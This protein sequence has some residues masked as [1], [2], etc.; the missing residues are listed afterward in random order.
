MHAILSGD[1]T[2]RGTRR[3]QMCISVTGRGVEL[4]R[5][6]TGRRADAMV[7]AATRIAR[8]PVTGA[9]LPF[10]TLPARLTVHRK[11]TITMY[12]PH[13][14][15]AALS[16]AA[17]P[18]WLRQRGAPAAAILERLR[19]AAGVTPRWYCSAEALQR[20]A[21]AGPHQLERVVRPRPICSGWQ[22]AR[23]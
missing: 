2:S 20:R 13:P 12:S 3:F 14:A 22:L 21:E 8:A 6:G 7:L 4:R 1:T 19:S 17:G 23:T 18:A 10:V 5:L 9:I 15:N 16:C 11:R